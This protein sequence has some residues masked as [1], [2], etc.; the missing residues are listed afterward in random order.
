[1]NRLRV[2]INTTDRKI[3][4]YGLQVIGEADI[5]N[6]ALCVDPR[7]WETDPGKCRVYELSL[8]GVVNLIKTLGGS[9]NMAINIIEVFIQYVE[10][11]ER[12][13]AAEAKV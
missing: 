7:T 13:F 9:E 1:M 10:E 5:P 11:A 6:L 12:R 4:D 2:V 8:H 3:G